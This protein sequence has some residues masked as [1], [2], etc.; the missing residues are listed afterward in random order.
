MILYCHCVAIYSPLGKLLRTFGSYGSGEGQFLNATSVALQPRAAS[1]GGGEAVLVGDAVTMSLQSF[2]LSGIFL[3]RLTLNVA[4]LRPDSA[5]NY[6]DET[7]LTNQRLWRPVAVDVHRLSNTV[8][9]GEPARAFFLL[10]SDWVPLRVWRHNFN[11]LSSFCVDYNMAL[12]ISESSFGF[13][14]CS[15]VVFRRLLD[16][17]QFSLAV[18]SPT[19]DADA[20]SVA[21]DPAG[22]VVCAAGLCLFL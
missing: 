14:T 3:R 7:W 22:R 5:A 21:V 16:D 9:V 6:P 18:G 4:T 1:D 11:V 17:Q 2:S 10:D 8:F 20:L 12:L 15:R 19:Q 13:P